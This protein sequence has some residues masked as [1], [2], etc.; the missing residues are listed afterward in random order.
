MTIEDA[1]KHLK[2]PYVLGSTMENAKAYNDAVSV[3]IRSLNAWGEVKDEIDDL[4]PDYGHEAYY[5]AV[6]DVLG[7]I[8]RHLEEVA[9]DN[10]EVCTAD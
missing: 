6:N 7:I 10:T 8:D 1:I 3:A 9:N 4:V 2:D 5:A